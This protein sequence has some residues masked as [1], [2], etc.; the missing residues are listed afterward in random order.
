MKKITNKYSKN[1]NLIIDG[2]VNLK[3]GFLNEQLAS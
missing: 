1:N 2:I 3:N